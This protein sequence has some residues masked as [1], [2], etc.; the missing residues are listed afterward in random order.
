MRDFRDA[1]AMAHSLRAALAAKGFKITVSQSLEL[2]AQA[3]GATDWNTLAAAIR[4]ET[5][6][7]PKSA[8]PPRSPTDERAPARFSAELESTLHRALAY[9]SQRKHEYTTLEHLLLALIDDLNASWVMKAC[10]VNL[11]ALRENLAGYID[12]DLK[13]LVI[14]VSRKPRPTPAFQRVVQRAV[15]HA[16]GLGR[17][18]A[19][20]GDLL[21]AI[22]DEK[23]SPAVWLLNEQEMIQQDVVNFILHGIVKDS[24]N[25]AG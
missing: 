20:G 3:F 16:Q 1:K 2:I 17:E 13:T 10:D 24:G 23:E 6:T 9:A 8:S 4:R 11:G 25:A 7:T 15:L 5:L 14:D 12:N 21:V 19:T 22:F 18:T